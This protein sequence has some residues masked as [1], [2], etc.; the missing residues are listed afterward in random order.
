MNATQVEVESPSIYAAGG[1]AWRPTAWRAGVL[2]SLDD[3]AVS[4][5]WDGVPTTVPMDEVVSMNLYRWEA[6]PE[7][8]G[9]QRRVEVAR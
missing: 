4:F 6:A 9:W 3:S 7:C 8:P 1:S 5:S 2:I